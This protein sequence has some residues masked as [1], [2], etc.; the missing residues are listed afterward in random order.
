[1]KAPATDAIWGNITFWPKD[2]EL[3][4]IAQ[5]L[6]ETSYSLAILFRKSFSLVNE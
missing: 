6:L 4:T 2:K 3:K 1:M 5:Q